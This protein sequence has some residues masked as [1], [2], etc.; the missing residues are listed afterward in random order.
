MTRLLFLLILGLLSATLADA[1]TELRE[2]DLRINGIGSGSS[3]SLVLSKLGKPIKRSYKKESTFEGDCM[4][5][6][7]TV[8]MLRYP[9]LEV[10][11]LGD[12]SG[13]DLKVVEMRM[14]SGGRTA[15]GIQL[16][17]TPGQIKK[18]FGEPNSTESRG[19]VSE[20]FYVTPGNLGAVKFRFT[21]GRLRMVGMS[22]T[23]C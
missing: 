13:K 6:D 10:V 7:Y 20:F 8:L 11:L 16:G 15:S 21:N 3:Y 4:G 12:G 17:S 9:G 1:Q 5:R 14:T 18:R 22:E 19:A 2:V 23:L